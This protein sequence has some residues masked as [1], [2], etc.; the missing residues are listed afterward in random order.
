[1]NFNNVVELIKEKFDVYVEH[2]IASNVMFLKVEGLDNDS[3]A[4]YILDNF[5]DV[6]VTVKEKEKYQF[7]SDW[8]KIEASNEKE[9]VL[10]K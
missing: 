8:I 9:L 4:R 1:L 10:T 7:S 2:E 5:K 3:L 6:K